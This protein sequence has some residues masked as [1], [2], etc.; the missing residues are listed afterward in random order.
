MNDKEGNSGYDNQLY[1][2]ISSI[3]GI[4]KG[5]Q[6]GGR[7]DLNTSLLGMAKR[8]SKLL[9]PLEVT[10][11]AYWTTHL[12]KQR[13]QQGLESSRIVLEHDGASTTIYLINTEAEGDEDL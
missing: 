3:V 5:I 8:L 6:K 4:E 10:E 9:A 7:E 13:L 1:Q 2:C 12:R 11:R